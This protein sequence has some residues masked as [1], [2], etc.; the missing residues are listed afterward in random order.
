MDYATKINI[1][2]QIIGRIFKTK[3]K[4]PVLSDRSVKTSEEHANNAE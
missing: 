4:K 2:F 1:Y 3:S